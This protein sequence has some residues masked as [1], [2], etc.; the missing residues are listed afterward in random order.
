MTMRVMWRDGMGSRKCCTRAGSGQRSAGSGERGAGSGERGA[1]S[2][3]RGA[4]KGERKAESGEQSRYLDARVLQRSCTGTE[5]RV[6]SY[7]ILWYPGTEQ[8]LEGSD[9]ATRIAIEELK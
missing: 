4:E 2:G 9:A 8:G 6:L 3:E 5:N 1:W 7:Q